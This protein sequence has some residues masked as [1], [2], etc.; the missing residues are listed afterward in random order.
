MFKK[1]VKNVKNTIKC[2]KKH[3]A[4]RIIGEPML[5][6]GHVGMMIAGGVAA[7]VALTIGAVAM[8]AWVGFEIVEFTAK[9]KEQMSR[10]VYCDAA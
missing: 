6:A 7:K 1:M 9:R 4:L 5:V 10:K 3:D 2:F 8:V